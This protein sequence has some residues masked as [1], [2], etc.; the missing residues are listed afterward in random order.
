MI[1]REKLFHFLEKDK[2]YPLLIS[3]TKDS[4]I[5]LTQGFNSMINKGF[6]LKTGKALYPTHF[7]FLG[8]LEDKE[9]FECIIRD[10]DDHEYFLSI[11]SSDVDNE[12]CCGYN[13]GGDIVII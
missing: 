3:S 10:N 9:A 2:F 8:V 11:E 6:V 13:N 4:N 12:V 7:K 5:R 1:Q